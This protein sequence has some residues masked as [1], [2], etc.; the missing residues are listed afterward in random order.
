[1]SRSFGSNVATAQDKNMQSKFQRFIQ[2]AIVAL[3]LSALGPALASEGYY[4]GL[5]YTFQIAESYA[6][7]LG[8][9]VDLL[10]PGGYDYFPTTW[11]SGA[12]R[13]TGTI[14]AETVRNVE[15]LF[16]TYPKLSTVYLDSPGGD[17]FAGIA[18]GEFFHS[19][20]IDVV[21]NG[22]AEC[23]SACALAFLGGTR[24]TLIGRTDGFGFHRQY[25]IVKGTVRYGS[26]A[27]DL[28]TINKYLTNVHADFIT[29]DEIVGT[30][31]LVTYSMQRL[32]SRGIAT[33]GDAEYTAELNKMYKAAPR[34]ISR[35]IVGRVS[36]L[37]TIRARS[38][39]PSFVR[40]WSRVFCCSWKASRTR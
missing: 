18:L 37:G 5:Y 25:Y 10:Q 40:P 34:H 9:E 8:G 11:A 21:K 1:M 24:R 7:L 20:Q 27:K 17:L 3:S 28:G 2:R 14:S 6:S 26:W 31:G 35:F 33:F 16:T 22:S 30:S 15:Y 29:A 36:L 23:A 32:R 4:S 38:R 12:V 39:G 13:V 19:R